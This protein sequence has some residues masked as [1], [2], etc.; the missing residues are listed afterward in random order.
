MITTED[1][2]PQ[3]THP[4]PTGHCQDHER[5][6]KAQLRTGQVFTFGFELREWPLIL[7][8]PTG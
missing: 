6:L 7:A 3:W 8:A 5:R 4:G 2:V 1:L